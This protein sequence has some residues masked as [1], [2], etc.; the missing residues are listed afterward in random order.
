[1]Y[2]D[3]AQEL[4]V[5]PEGDLRSMPAYISGEGFDIAGIKCVNVHP[6]NAASYSLTQND[7][8]PILPS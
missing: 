1:V 4:F 7:D 2:S 6:Q 8:F 5:F 3:A